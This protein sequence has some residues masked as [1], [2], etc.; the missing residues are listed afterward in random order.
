MSEYRDRLGALGYSV[1][2]GIQ[3]YAQTH[4]YIEQEGSTAKS[5]LKNLFRRG[6]QMSRLLEAAE[7]LLPIWNDIYSNIMF[8]E[9][10]TAFLLDDD[11]SRYL[12]ALLKYVKRVKVA[13][14]ALVE[15]QRYLTQSSIDW[16]THLAASQKYLAAM[17]S[18]MEAEDEMN[19]ASLWRKT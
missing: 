1:N 14:E 6:T 13:I 7:S 10:Q 2:Q 19:R 11:E 15:R 3:L 18:F 9:A 16:S 12:D 5:A 4:K 17:S 8:F